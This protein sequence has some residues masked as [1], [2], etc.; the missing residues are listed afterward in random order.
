MVDQI[1][2]GTAVGVPQVGEPTL[3]PKLSLADAA[4]DWRRPAAEVLGRILGTT[5]EP[6]AFLLLDGGARLKVLEA[7]LAHDAAVPPGRSPHDDGRI[8]L[9][10]GTAPGGARVAIE[11]LQVLPAGKRPMAAADWWRGRSQ[12]ELTVE[13]WEQ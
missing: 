1:A 3:A 8:L 10:V 5:P 2:A 4:I 9:G 11:L 7:A 13:L 12:S 6:G